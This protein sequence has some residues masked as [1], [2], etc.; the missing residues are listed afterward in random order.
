MTGNNKS[1]KRLSEYDHYGKK[2]LVF[3]TIALCLALLSF[4]VLGYLAELSVRF[5]FYKEI[6]NCILLITFLVLLIAVVVLAI[7][8]IISGKKGLKSNK[9][10]L[11]ITGL[12]LSIIGLSIPLLGIIILLIYLSAGGDIM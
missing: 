4:W 10:G 2:S 7:L 3:G 9:A 11:S 8:G 6:G 5:N 1:Q 12:V